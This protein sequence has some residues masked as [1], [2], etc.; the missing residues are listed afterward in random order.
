MVDWYQ[1]WC[2][3]TIREVLMPI[4]SRMHG[5]MSIVLTIQNITS[6]WL[7]IDITSNFPRIVLCVWINN[8]WDVRCLVSWNAC[9]FGG[10]GRNLA[11]P[12]SGCREE[13]VGFWRSATGKSEE[14]DLALSAERWHWTRHGVMAPTCAM[15]KVRSAVDDRTW[16]D[17]TWTVQGMV[18]SIL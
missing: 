11:K 5:E 17:R 16:T 8:D 14:A 18:S 6:I 12:I 2:A 7:H 15:Y 3:R 10:I 1:Q 9:V 4:P 13:I